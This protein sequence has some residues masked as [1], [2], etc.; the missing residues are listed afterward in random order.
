M[1]Q[2]ITLELSVE[3]FA[4]LARRAKDAGVAPA[5][6]AAETLEVQYGGRPARDASA[7]RARFERLIGA[8]ELTQPLG[9]DNEA[10]DA[11]LARADDEAG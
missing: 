5:Q 11:D 8:I 10:I 3:A 7:A 4:G 9:T 6:L 1:S 2:A